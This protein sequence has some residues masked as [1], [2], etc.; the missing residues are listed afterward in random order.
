VCVCVSLQLEKP[1]CVEAWPLGHVWVGS[2]TAFTSD[3]PLGVSNSRPFT[4]R[5]T[6][7]ANVCVFPG[8]NLIEIGQPCSVKLSALSSNVTP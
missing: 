8:G 6:A 2:H 4:A 7:N 3:K 1:G 5:K